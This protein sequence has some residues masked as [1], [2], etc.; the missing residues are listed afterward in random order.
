[1]KIKSILAAMLLA[2]SLG[3]A[4]GPKLSFVRDVV[5]IF[6]M[7][8]CA[9][10]NCH[11][12]IRGKNGFKLSLFGYEPALDFEAITGGDGHRID[13]AH[14]EKSL[15][16]LKPTFQVA[17]GGGLRFAVDSLEYRTILQWVEDGATYDSPGSPRIS[18]LNVTPASRLLTGAGATE[19]LHATATYTDGTTRDVTRLVQYTSNNPDVA[20]VSAGGAVKALMPGET[21]IMVRTLGK[22]AVSRVEIAASA[23][24]PDYPALRPRN[25]VDEF[26]FA[27]LKRLNIRPSGDSSD[28]EF[29][30]RVYIDSIGLLPTESEA[31]AFFQS[32]DPDKR[33]KV[34]DRLLERPEFAELWALKFSELFRAGTYESGPKGAR[35]VYEWLRRSFLENKPWDKMVGELVLSQG[36]HFF[37]K[38]PSSFYNISKDSDA[39]D[40]ATN[41]SQL[42]LGVR[43]EC[44]RCHNHPW[45]KWTQDDFYGFAAFFARVGVKEVYENDENANYYMEEGTVTNPKTKLVALPKYLDGPL[46]KDAPDK[47]IR[48]DLVRW[49]VAPG[50]PF[51]SRAIVNRMWKHYMGRGLV[52]E[53]DDF[54][55]TNPPS[56]PA[57]LDALAKD[58]SGNRYD[59]RHLVRAILNSRTYQLT[60]E[61]NESNRG[62][63]ID[64]S[65]YYMRRMIAEEIIDTMS[66]VTGVGER[67]KGYPPETR[68]MQVYAAGSPNY[69]LGAFG[70]P[71]RDTI[72]ERDPQPDIVQ[73][74]HLISGDTIQKKLV[75]WKPDPALSDE[76][77]IDRIFLSSLTRLPEAEEKAKVLGAAKTDRLN[78]F[79]DLLWAIL[80]SKEFLYNH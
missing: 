30:R 15:I 62:D 60:A 18:S 11:G 1:M 33:S 8:G 34:I 13:K 57:L 49:M 3:A 35:I 17:H 72:C 9:G 26:V 28:S 47:D 31:L 10:S 21:A 75:K 19:Q 59:L 36:A 68:A 23:T 46:E 61:P 12:S 80:N 6:T 64:Y 40:N 43:I 7:A 32:K 70:R 56:N 58:L 39:P 5:P 16:L 29:L 54:R 79:Q 24:P 51:F 4:D 63:T 50:N 37:G 69:M 22:A 76:Q 25:Y 71:S 2:S 73:T 48:E 77:T 65:H 14:A 45:E 27:K 53:V 78:A 74:L 38:Q 44:A 42:F 66:Q 55:I 20:Q 41:I 67:F 52:E